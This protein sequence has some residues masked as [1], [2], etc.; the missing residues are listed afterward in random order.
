MERNWIKGW[1]ETKAQS[2][3]KCRDAISSMAMKATRRFCP[4][5][6][7]H[8]WK[9]SCK[10]WMVEM[11]LVSC[12]NSRFLHASVGKF[13]R[14]RIPRSTS[15]L[16]T[17]AWINTILYE[18]SL[19]YLGRPHTGHHRKPPSGKMGVMMNRM[20]KKHKKNEEQR[21]PDRGTRGP[22]E[23]TGANRALQGDWP[24]DRLEHDVAVFGRNAEPSSPLTGARFGGKST[25]GIS[26]S[27]PKSRVPPYVREWNW[28][29]HEE[30]TLSWDQ[31]W[32][33][34]S[35]ESVKCQRGFSVSSKDCVT[36]F[37]MSADQ[38]SNKFFV[39]AGKR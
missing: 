27:N 3:W 28:D 22:E 16:R 32:D 39:G 23:F 25:D 33:V 35:V 10:A 31:E 12:H 8:D 14:N 34:F 18:S 36:V 9:R 11:D 5:F 7:E 38:L 29:L 2:C 13:A 19:G 17:G 4:S 24:G 6:M 15:V 30:D 37:Q 26:F 1:F 20:V 21:R